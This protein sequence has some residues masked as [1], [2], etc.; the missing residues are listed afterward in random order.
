MLQARNSDPETGE[1]LRLISTQIERIT[2]VLREMMEFASTRP[3]ERVPL[4][5]NRAVEA[6]LRLASFDKAFQRLRINKIFDHETPL[7]LADAN[8]LQQVFLNILLN[9]R[10]AMPEGGDL[11]VHTRYDIESEEVIVEIS[12]GGAGIAPEHVAHIFDPFF[13]TKP[14][15]AGTGLGLAVSYRIVTAHGGRIEVAPNNGLGT[16]VRVRLPRQA[17]EAPKLTHAGYQA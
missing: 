2:Q 4:D 7:I 1:Q 11:S 17:E 3:P 13:T 5:I 16:T 12:D 14:A 10:D 9:A 6:S 15:G 8:Q